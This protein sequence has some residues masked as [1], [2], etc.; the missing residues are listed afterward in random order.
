MIVSQPYVR[1]RILGLSETPELPGRTMLF[2]TGN[3][4]SVFGD[5]SR[6]T[7]MCSLDPKMERP[8]TREFKSNPVAAVKADRG[9]YVCAALTILR[10]YRLAKEP[11]PPAFASFEEWSDTVRGGLIWLGCADPVATVET[12][13]ASDT[14]LEELN[15]VLEYWHEA[16]GDTTTSVSD[17]IIKATVGIDA[18]IGLR[19]AL[20]AVAGERGTINPRRLG[21]W[22]SRNKERLVGGRRIVRRCG[23]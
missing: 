13:R 16:I 11:R 23:L 21:R 6:R 20:H 22:L 10:A 19:E 4:L 15:A 12:V 8:E 3:N 2:A 18:A 17:L 9:R 5:M 14:K 1:A 7:I